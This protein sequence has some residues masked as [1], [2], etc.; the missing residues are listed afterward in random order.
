MEKNNF[1]INRAIHIAEEAE[2]TLAA[3][4][5]C[6]TESKLFPI[7]LADLQIQVDNLMYLN[8]ANNAVMNE[9]AYSVKKKPRRKRK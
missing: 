6:L 2:K 9:K 5:R 4:K 7:Y 8:V 3:V 1:Y